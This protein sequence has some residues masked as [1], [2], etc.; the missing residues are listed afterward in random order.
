MATR[1]EHNK[2]KS[3]AKACT[4]P[5][6]RSNC[7]PTHA[8]TLRELVGTLPMCEDRRLQ[9][10]HCAGLADTWWPNA[11][12][13]GWRRLCLWLGQNLRPHNK[14]TTCDYADWLARCTQQRR[15]HSEQR[16]TPKDAT[17]CVSRTPE[18][19]PD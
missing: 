15:Q 16:E 2:N 17:V 19:R 12:E 9:A 4:H 5:R 6:M 13:L 1:R 14:Q 10:E 18:G 7:R 8:P 3:C 11:P